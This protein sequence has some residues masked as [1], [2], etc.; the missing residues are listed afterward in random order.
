MNINY[1]LIDRLIYKNHIFKKSLISGTII[2]TSFLTFK[3]MNDNNE[4]I[5]NIYLNDWK[6][7]EKSR[8]DKELTDFGQCLEKY[9]DNFEKCTDFLEAYKRCLQQK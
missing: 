7:K 5:N 3:Y 1:M 8:C 4:D 9:N 2:A 6:I